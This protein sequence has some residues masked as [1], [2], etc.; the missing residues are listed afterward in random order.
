M[1]LSKK[2][3]E[4]PPRSYNFYVDMSE[5][6]HIIKEEKNNEKILQNNFR[7]KYR[8]KMK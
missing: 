3:C 1:N 4:S 5:K 8:R 6:G 7:V 2:F